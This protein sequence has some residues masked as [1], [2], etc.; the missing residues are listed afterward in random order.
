M[1]SCWKF[2]V[3]AWVFVM[4]NSIQVDSIFTLLPSQHI[5][6]TKSFS[7]YII[8]VCINLFLLRLNILTRHKTNRSRHRRNI[9]LANKLILIVFQTLNLRNV[10]H[11][12]GTFSFTYGVNLR[13]ELTLFVESQPVLAS[14]LKSFLVDTMEY[15][16]WP[17]GFS[18]SLSPSLSLAV[19]CITAVSENISR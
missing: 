2:N 19:T 16:I 4:F 5:W 8:I 6:I 17:A 11:K 15:S 12:K 10:F 3:F 7:Q 1:C 14:I 18:G 9:L 13:R